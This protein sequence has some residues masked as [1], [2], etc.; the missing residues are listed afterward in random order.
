MTSP[1]AG[2]IVFAFA[3]GLGAMRAADARVSAIVE[4]IVWDAG[5][6]DVFP[7]LLFGPTNQRVD[8]H[9]LPLMVPL[10]RAGIRALEC[11][12][13]ADRCYPRAASTQRIFE[14]LELSQPAAKIG[15]SRPQLRSK[16]ILLLVGT[17]LGLKCANLNLV[18]IFETSSQ[19]VCFLE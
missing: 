17:E 9:Q 1:S 13:P 14:W 4:R 3:D 5:S 8:L 6:G 2:S 7:N 12:I 11:L 18:A 10:D 19:L 15:I 16:S